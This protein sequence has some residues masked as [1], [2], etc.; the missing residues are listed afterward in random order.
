MYVKPNENGNSYLIYRPSTDQ[1]V[2][3]KDYRTVPVPE[4]LVDTICKTDPYDNKSK[5]D[6]FD[7]IHSI[8]HDDQSNNY[9]NND[10]IPFSN[11]DQYLQESL[12]TALSL[13]ASLLVL[14]HE[15]ILHYLHN[16][17][18]TVV[19]VLLSLLMYL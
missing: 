8:A 14:I 4:D 18:S 15:D 10:H 16:D 9:N 13:Q 3:I 5:V 19:H 11:E 2:V 6:D 7:M 17:I 1:I 12:S